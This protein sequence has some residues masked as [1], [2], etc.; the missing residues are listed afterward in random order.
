MKPGALLAAVVLLAANG[1]FVAAEFALLAS[2]RSRI[3][4]LAGEG[5]RRATH[6][7]A[8]IRELSLMLAAAQLGITMAS[9]GLGAVAEPALAA[10]LEIVFEGVGI[11]SAL[12][13]AVAFT[14][15]LAVVVFLHMVV[16]EMAPKSWA[17]ANPERSALALARPFRAFA[18]L[19]RPAIS[20]LN[21]MANGL[22]RLCG[23]EPQ[24]ELATAHAPADLLL[25]VEESARSGT[26]GEEQHGLLSRA[27]DLS[28]LD[29]EAA[30]V[31]RR[32]V[33]AVPAGATVDEIERIASTTG[34]SRLPVYDDDLDHVRGVLHVKDVL[35]LDPSQ[36][37]TTT[38]ATLARPAFVTVESRPI[39][40]LM[41]DMR[42]ERAHVAIVVDEY[43]SVSGLVALEDLL[44]ELIGDFEDETDP[45]LRAGSR[46]A[47]RR[48]PDG[49]LLV[50]GTLR[51]DELHARAGVALP[52]GDYETVAGFVLAALGRVPVEGDRVPL[53]GG[54]L[55]VV[56]MDGP[57]VVDLALRTG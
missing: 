5:D 51:P 49:A 12:R 2:R 23:V 24:G 25:L 8:G 7:L 14:V 17:I 33:V 11:P 13:H 21:A 36:R 55:E 37:D 1:L 46:R 39:E 52:D 26:L 32:D 16:G 3:E 18:L 45:T 35:R 48:R 50:P 19:L 10:G 22:V 56:R 57:R 9:L 6:A 31:P 44:E 42:R 29:A 15:A 28:G 4:Q 38:A 34:R 40:D 53:D 20:A 30:M 47:L 54:S 43:G 27:L 41:L